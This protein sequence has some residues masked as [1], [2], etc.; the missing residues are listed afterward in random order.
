M[1]FEN[2]EDYVIE[3]AK[4]ESPELV[5]E[6][7][8]TQALNQKMSKMEEMIRGQDMGYSINFEDMKNI[9]GDEPNTKLRTSVGDLELATQRRNKSFLDSLTRFINNVDLMKDELTEEDEVRMNVWDIL[10]NLVKRLQRMNPKTF[11]NLYNGLQ[12]IED[13]R[14]NYQ[15]RGRQQ[16]GTNRI[17]NT[18]A[19]QQIRRFSNFNQ[20]FSKVLE[21]LVQKGLL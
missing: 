11:T 20:P 8:Q 15:T 19:L 6:S 12:A 7:K 1:M 13:E 5:Q 14:K 3:K 18:N 21:C 10:P 9:E 16:K 2:M 17:T 4:K